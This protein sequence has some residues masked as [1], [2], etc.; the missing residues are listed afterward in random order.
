MHSEKI[1]LKEISKLTPCSY[2]KFRWWRKYIT[3]ETPISKR[4]TIKDKIDVGYYDF[5]KSY[6]WQAQQALLELKNYHP[7]DLEKRGL[8]RTRYK[9]LMEDY[10]KEE[11]IKLERIIEDFTNGYMLKKEQVKEILENFG[12]DIRDLYIMFEKKYKYPIQPTYK[13][14]F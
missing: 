9:R 2:N 12:G 5:P 7:E 3:G 4:A 13:R 10:Y 11:N 14:S 1:I 8:I 6:F